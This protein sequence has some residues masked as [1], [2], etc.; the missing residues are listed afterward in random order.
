MSA[1]ERTGGTDNRGVPPL[2]G[3]CSYTDAE[4][5]GLSVEETVTRLK[6][7]AYTLKRLHGTAVAHLAGTAEWEVKC[8]LGLHLWLDAEHCSGIHGRIAE[9][10]EPPLHLDAVPDARLEALFEELIRAPGAAELL[11]GIYGVVRP[12]LLRAIRTHLE[13]MNP[14]FDFPTRRLLRSIEREQEE[15]IAWGTVAAAALST[16]PGREEEFS[17]HLDAYLADAGGIG[18]GGGRPSPA[19][20]LPAPAWDG[21]S[22]YEMEVEPRRDERF[23]D[24][25]NGS[26]DIDAYYVDDARAADERTWALAYKR[27]REMDVPEWMAPILYKTFGKPWAY[28]TD[29]SRQLW[30]ETRHAMMGEVALHSLGIPFYDYPVD[31]ASSWTLNMEFTPLEAHLL[32]WHVE[33]GL[34]PRET[35]KRL[36]WVIARASGEPLLV[37]LQDFDWADEVLHAQIGRRWL[38]EDLPEPREWHALGEALWARWMDAIDR[39]R[40][41]SPQYEW[42]DEFVAR[43]RAGGV[44]EKSTSGS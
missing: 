6:R 18:G 28:Y 15:M 42:W 10:R 32:L 22:A 38:R 13:E 23:A 21:E 9:M 41:R 27:L 2:A 34:M 20:G 3:V 25:F 17:T 8:G 33:Q 11:V 31:V 37:T 4:R 14:L 35:G 29:L 7:Y 36:E 43:A 24:Q 5:P 26:A 39:T 40:S 30:D 16:S 12:G 44:P 19:A 1:H